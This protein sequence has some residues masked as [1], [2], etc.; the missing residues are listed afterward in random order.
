MPQ[1]YAY[2]QELELEIHDLTQTGQGVGRDEGWVIM[3]PYVL[4]GER[5]RVR[6]Y[7]NH[8]SYSDADLVA[9]LR[10]SPT[11]KRPQCALFGECG[12]CQYQHSPLDYQRLLK[13]KHVAECFRRIAKYADPPVTLTVGSEHAY[14]YRSKLTPHYDRQRRAIGFMRA[15]RRQILDLEQ[16][17]IASEAINAALPAARERVRLAQSKRGGTLLLRDNG[18]EVIEDMRAP[19]HQRVGDLDF[20][21]VAGG[22]FQNNPFAL[23]LMIGVVRDALLESDARVLVDAYCGAGLFALSCA[24]DVERVIGLEIAEDAVR[25]ATKNAESNAI[26]NCHFV[27][28]DAAAL[29]HSVD[30]AAEETAVIIDPPRKGCDTAFL[31][32]LDAFRPRRLIYVSCD[33]ATQA[34]DVGFLLE[35][36]W[37]LTRITPIDLFPQTRHIESVAVLQPPTEHP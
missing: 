28:G 22:F 4:P 10:P 27:A 16:C 34:R 37:T 26:H 23:P 2:H 14:G 21:Y 32:Q 25:L 8:A 6:I 15:G 12:G 31:E 24:A 35:R 30:S 29:F 18:R 5:V 3:V 36:G 7:R 17:P 19:T 33:P 1:P 20:A 9:V 11:R 13:Q